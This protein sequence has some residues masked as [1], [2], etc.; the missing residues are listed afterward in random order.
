[1]KNKSNK[2]FKWILLIVWMAVIF[3]MSNQPGDVSSEQSRLVVVIFEFLGLEISKY[4]DMATFLIRKTAHFTEYFILFLLAYRVAC[5][6]ISEK[7]ARI[8]VI[9]FVFLYACTD[10]IHQAFIPDRAPAFRDVLIDTS[11]GVFASFLVY[12]IGKFKRK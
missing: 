2:I 11:G 5:M 1:M 10:E 4:G 3:I 9:L 6:Y 7:K 12:L 8:Y